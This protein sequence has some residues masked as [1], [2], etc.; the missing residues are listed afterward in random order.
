[1]IMMKTIASAL[2][3]LTVLASVA[4]PASAEYFYGG[5]HFDARQF[6]EYLQNHSG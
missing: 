5:D 3:A 1:M 6:F 4:A 2:L